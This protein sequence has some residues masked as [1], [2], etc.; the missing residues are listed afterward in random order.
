MRL[1]QG[2]EA[3]YRYG[4]VLLL[5]L[6]AVVFFI[7][8]PDD[9]LSHVLALL[10]TLAMLLVVVVTGRGDVVV[11]GWTAAIAAVLAVGGSIAIAVDNLP[12]WVGSA[13]GVVLVSVTIV[14]VVRGLARLL[15]DRG[16]TLQ[17]VAGA[18]AV[19]LLLG[20]FFAQLVTVGAHIGHE[21]FFSQGTDGT[22][23]DHVYYAFTTMTTTGYGDFTPATRYGRAIAVLAMLVGQI[24]LV[25][26]IAM[27]V[28]NLRRRRQQDDEQAG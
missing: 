3:A 17:A 26:V 2:Q 27:L 10:L 8:A 5:A 9:P 15:S 13:V 21:P 20:L 23:S 1:S 7:V 19:Y 25:T 11:R 16:V 4:L 6:A 28:G 18:L 12:T 14:E 24:Y 22:E